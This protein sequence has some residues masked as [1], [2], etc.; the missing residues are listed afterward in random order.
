MKLLMLNYEFPPIGGGAGLAHASLL[1]EFA[2][3]SDLHVDVITCGTR[4]GVTRETFAAGVT[5]YR[6][7]IHKKNPH[8]WKR[9]EVIQWLLRAHRPYQRLLRQNT[10]RLVHAFFG[11]PSGWL[12]YCSRKRLPYIISLRGV[13]VPGGNPRFKL[14]Y[15]LLGPLL[16]SPIWR[17]ASRIVSCSEGLRQRALDFMPRTT[18]EVIPNGVDL[19]RFQ[20]APQRP[21]SPTLRLITVGRLSTNKRVNMLVDAVVLLNQQGCP[22]HLTVVG[23]GALYGSLTQRIHGTGFTHLISLTGWCEPDQIPALY[24]RSDLYVSA[25]LGEGM[26]NAMLEAMASALPIVTTDCEGVD[27]LIGTNG[28]VT[29]PTPA[30]LAEAIRV[31]A[32]NPRRRR[33]MSREAR[34]KA[35]D[36]SW[37]S[38]AQAYINLYQDLV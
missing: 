16:F 22:T 15:K 23:D 3:R 12:C 37:A 27:E 21:V 34:A 2:A 29:E 4:P 28:M 30:A 32:A 26:S 18:I 33:W 20:P 1:K 19:E 31:L 11:F 14:E 9:S 25:T 35:Q 8:F 13:D 24:R 7:G 17:H 10:Y 5:I 36:F 38:A 6:V